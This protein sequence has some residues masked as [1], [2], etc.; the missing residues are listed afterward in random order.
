M[1]SPV[2][3][4]C[5]C[6][7]R[8]SQSLNLGVRSLAAN[9]SSL[10]GTERMAPAC[11][12]RGRRWVRGAREGEHPA[13]EGGGILLPTALAVRRRGVREFG[14][15]ESMQN[16]LINRNVGKQ[17]TSQKSCIPLQHVY[18]HLY[19]HPVCAELKK[20]RKNRKKM[21][22]RV[23]PR[24]GVVVKN[25]NLNRPLSHERGFLRATPL[26]VLWNLVPFLIY[27][28]IYMLQV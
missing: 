20:N 3:F 11:L 15:M 8:R 27:I 23:V 1:S 22:N 19:Y 7:A 26:G 12:G 17:G 25:S 9:A 18:R 13:R 5:S 24:F 21:N 10:A 28:Y 14:V 6:V 2:A 16:K 4:C